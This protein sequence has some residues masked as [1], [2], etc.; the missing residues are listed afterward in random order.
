LT[1]TLPSRFFNFVTSRVTGIRLHDF[2]CG[3]KAYRRELVDEL[4]LYGEMHRY[5]PVLASKRGFAVAEVRV[6]H[7]SRKYGQSKFGV[8]R[9][10]SGFFDLLTVLFLTH[11]QWRP[12]HLMGLGGV[13]SLVL[14][15]VILVYLTVLWFRGVRPIGNRPLLTLG[16]LLV[17]VGVQFFTMGLLAE[18]LVKGYGGRE[19]KVSIRRR[20]PAKSQ[21][22][23]AGPDE[24]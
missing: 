15:I 3:L 18:L 8:E 14:G 1:K 4:E 12:L 6:K 9:M 23:V 16:V 22:A 19:S 17:I 21:E 5:L 10:L 24:Q 2:N 7:R 20:L 13:A 11:Y